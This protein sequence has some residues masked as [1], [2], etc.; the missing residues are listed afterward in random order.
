[1]LLS[2]QI[3]EGVSSVRL[4]IVKWFI[5]SLGKVVQRRW[6]GVG[7]FYPNV[8]C[9]DSIV[10]P[11]HFHGIIEITRYIQNADD[12]YES[13]KSRRNMILPKIIGRFKMQTSKEINE[14]RNS[15]GQRLW[16]RNYYERIIHDPRGYEKVSRYI[17][18]NPANWK[19][20]Q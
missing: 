12:L 10:M 3:R 1:M 4:L 8:I 13:C 15:P 20:Y 9:R 2:I 6:K 18:H 17:R 16:Q 7:H 5:M 14:L 11:D 19:K